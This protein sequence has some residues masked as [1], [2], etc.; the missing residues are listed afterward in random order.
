MY[1]T[2]IMYVEIMHHHGH[3]IIGRAL[4]RVSVCPTVMAIGPCRPLFPSIR[5]I[6]LF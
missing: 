5:S 1:I 3:H 6:L 4:L 2:I